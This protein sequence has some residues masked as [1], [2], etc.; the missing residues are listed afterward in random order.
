MQD[1]QNNK[2]KN[3]E[4]I[5]LARRKLLAGIAAASVGGAGLAACGS[6]SSPDASAVTQV[7]PDPESS[8]IDHIVVVMMENRSFDHYFSWVSGATTANMAKLALKDSDG[9]TVSSRKLTDYQNCSLADPDHSY[10]GGR[11]HYNDGAMDGFL[12]TQPVGDDFPVGYYL[13]D[14][15]PFYKGVVANWTLCDHYFSGILS[16][17]Y[18]NRMYMHGG[19]TDRNDNSVKPYSLTSVW[20]A[21][22]SVGRTG[23]YYYTDAAG[24]ALINVLMAGHN[25]GAANIR[26]FSRFLTDAANGDLADVT[27]I[28]PAFLS[29]GDGTSAD[30]HPLA[31]IRKG[32]VWLNQIYDALRSSPAWE[33]TLLIINYDEWGGFYDHVAPPYAPVSYDEYKDTGNDGLLGFRVPCMAIGPRAK[34]GHLEQRQFDPNSILN[35]IAWRFGFAPLGARGATSMNFAQLLDFDSAPNLDAPAFDVPDDDSWGQA[36]SSSTSSISAEHDA[37]VKRRQAE[38]LEEWQGLVDIAYAQGLRPDSD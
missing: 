24:W 17:T 4:N 34:R 16:S 27:F 1:Q 25:P 11:T 21:L 28:D 32:Q 2:N 37:E 36:C 30:D 31:D 19:Q 13:A 9:N 35:M 8:G 7:L 12:L 15:L 26:T 22:G 6:S 18:P 10:D 33:K 20:D 14:D 38:H 23:R 29:E 5:D 3:K